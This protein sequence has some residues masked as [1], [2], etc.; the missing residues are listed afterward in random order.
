VFLASKQVQCFELYLRRASDN[1]ISVFVLAAQ[2]VLLY[3]C[4][5]WGFLKSFSIG[6]NKVFCLA[7]LLAESESY[8]L[9]LPSLCLFVLDNQ[10]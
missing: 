3:N 9:P 5:A 8:K 2:V 7:S 6:I 1:T 4:L 10:R